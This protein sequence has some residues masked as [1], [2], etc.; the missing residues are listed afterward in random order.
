MVATAL[1][2]LSSRFATSL[3]T[4][5]VSLILCREI[6]VSALR[7]RMAEKGQRDNVQVGYIGK[8]K[9]C[10]QMLSTSLLLLVV[11]NSSASFDLC[12]NVFCRRKALIFTSGIVSLY[13]SMLLT[14]LSGFMYLRAAWPSLR[15]EEN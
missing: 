6:G 5:P 9:T 7:E 14:L 3:Y 1:I 12:I 8:L 11:P 10:F 15:E 2:L 4:V 13:A